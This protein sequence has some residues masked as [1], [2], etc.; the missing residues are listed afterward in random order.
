[1][2]DFW[3]FYYPVD[4]LFIFQ[5]E[6]RSLSLVY[7]VSKRSLN[8]TAI[9][10]LEFYYYFSFGI[11]M[12]VFG[13]FGRRVVHSELKGEKITI[14]RAFDFELFD[15]R[16]PTEYICGQSREDGQEEIIPRKPDA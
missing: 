2:V 4:K 14:C 10:P 16:V 13:H 5:A 8:E 9:S 6:H 7:E 3:R 1:M 11:A 15:R 12:E